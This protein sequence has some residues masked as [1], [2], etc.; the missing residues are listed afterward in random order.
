MSITYDHPLTAQC[1]PNLA[2]TDTDP[3][4]IASGFKAIL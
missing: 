2:D 4:T 1:P 3:R